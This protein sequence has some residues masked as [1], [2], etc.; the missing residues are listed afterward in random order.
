MAAV[1]GTT[2]SP[3]VI[4]SVT[5]AGETGTSYIWDDGASGS[6]TFAGSETVEDVDA[7]LAMI[8]A[9]GLPT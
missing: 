5:Y 8:E 3:T 2:G 1:T 6:I 7:A 4:P 9:A